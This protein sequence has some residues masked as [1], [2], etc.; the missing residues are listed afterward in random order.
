MPQSDDALLHDEAILVS[1]H[2][3]AHA[4][5]VARM[6]RPFTHNEV[7][8]LHAALRVLR[9]GWRARGVFDVVESVSSMDGTVFLLRAMFDAMN[10]V[11]SAD[12]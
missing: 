5:H 12:W 4:S 11:F 6:R 8:A 10:Q 3:G 7:R 9:D 2:D 1:V